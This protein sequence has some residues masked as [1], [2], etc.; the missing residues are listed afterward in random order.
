VT[1]QAST[2]LKTLLVGLDGACREVLDPL[3]ADGRLPALASIFEDGVVA[4]LESQIPPWTPSAWPSMYTGVNPGKHGVFDFLTFQGYDWRVVDRSHVREHALWEL[5]DRRGL[6]SVVVNV[7]VTAPPL[8]FD[9]ALLPG[10]VAPED[11][12]GHPDGVLDRVRDE[13]G[14]YRVYAPEDVTGD[15]QVEW[16]QRLVRMR[17]EAFRV[18]AD[19]FEPEFGFLQF[20]QTDT[21]FHERPRDDAAARAVYQTVD[22]ELAKTLAACDPDTVFV[23]SDHGIGPLEGREFRVNEYFRDRGLLETTRG[24]GGMPSWTAYKRASG[25]DDDTPLSQRVVAAA[26]ALG[27]TSRRIGTVLGSLGLREF[28]LEHVSTDTVRAGTERVD[29]P[30]STV[31]MRSRTELGVRINKAGRDPDGVVSPSEFAS[32]RADVVSALREAR[33]PDGSRV[34]DEVAPAEEYFHGPYVDEAVD[35]VAVPADFQNFLSASLNGDVFADAP[36]QWNHKLY[37]VLALAGDA[38]DADAD[39]AQPHLFDVAPSVLATLDVPPSDRM[40]GEQLS[41]V[42]S[43]SPEQYASFT[44]SLAA[45]DDDDAVTRRLS[46]L[47][48]VEDDDR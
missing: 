42:E 13:L 46:N 47:G 25:E 39:L 45:A 11:P 19:D 28:V 36:E 35:V 10:Y 48:Y 44:A 18:L 12:T 4:P 17:G 3:L 21:V 30:S 14:E 43:V 31:Y 6:T 41:P 2:G 5:L 33:T 38:V 34:F 15:E 1:G 24:D 26:A 8:P 20:Q 7:P 16:Y 23:V 37:G 29:F 9:G 22:D 32:V 40:D 27:I